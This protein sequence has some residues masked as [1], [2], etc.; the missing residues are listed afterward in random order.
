MKRVLL[1]AMLVGSL[2][3]VAQH[4]SH[5]SN[6]N[7]SHSQ[8]RYVYENNRNE[9]NHNNRNSNAS[10]HSFYFTSKPFYNDLYRLDLSNYQ[11]RELRNMIGVMYSDIQYAQRTYRNPKQ[12][13]MTIEK[14]FDHKLRQLFN[15]KQY[16]KW[17]QYYAY[18]YVSLNYGR[19]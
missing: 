3:A 19:G 6:R 14:A 7:A 11:D 12:N 16:R 10:Y 4:R 13:I 17:N 5:S 15:A 2:N 8:P 9:H 18:E 1:I